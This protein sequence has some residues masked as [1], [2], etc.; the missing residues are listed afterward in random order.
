MAFILAV[1]SE[2]KSRARKSESRSSRW[3]LR[4]DETVK[5]WPE[6][7]KDTH[8]GGLVGKPGTE[9]HLRAETMNLWTQP[10]VSPEVLPSTVETQGWEKS[11]SNKGWDLARQECRR[12]DTWQLKTF[13]RQ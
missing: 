5:R 11:G 6:M 1:K 3:M 10:Q 13:L 4:R 9:E 7:G 2:A 8:Q 12:R